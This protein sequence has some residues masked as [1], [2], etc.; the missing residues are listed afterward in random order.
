MGKKNILQS[1]GITNKP[2]K[3]L[4]YYILHSIKQQVRINKKFI[5]EVKIPQGTVLSTILH[6]IIYVCY[7]LIFLYSR[8]DHYIV[9]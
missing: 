6:I 4:E 2:L 9:F 3:L 1:I 7:I 5:D 8:R